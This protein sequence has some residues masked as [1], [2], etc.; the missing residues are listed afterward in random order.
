MDD[1]DSIVMTWLFGSEALGVTD[2]LSGDKP[3]TGKLPVT[4][5]KETNHADKSI[6]SD[7]YEDYDFQFDFGFGLEY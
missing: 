4:W 2:V 6:Y 1:F 5:P 3:F 7:D